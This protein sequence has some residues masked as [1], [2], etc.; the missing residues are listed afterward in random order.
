MGTMTDSDLDKLD[1]QAAELIMGWSIKVHQ[2]GNRSWEEW[3][4]N[5]V[6][7]MLVAKDILIGEILVNY[8]QPTRNISQAF[9]LLEKTRGCDVMVSRRADP[10]RDK[11]GLEWVCQLCW[12]RGSIDFKLIHEEAETA[13]LAITLACLKSCGVE[14][15]R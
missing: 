15:D 4:R 10:I 7:Q 5:G 8:W 14:I 13:P 1:R 2:Q 3:V 6:P 9:E 12:N 11:L